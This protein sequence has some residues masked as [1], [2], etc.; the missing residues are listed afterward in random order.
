MANPTDYRI[1]RARVE[2]PDEPK[3]NYDTSKGTEDG[4]K[5][6]DSTHKLHK[7]IDQQLRAIRSGRKDFNKKADKY[8]KK[9]LKN[10]KK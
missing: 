5:K 1:R 9:W 10:K 8:G 6:A 4:R 3:K 2:R 7:G